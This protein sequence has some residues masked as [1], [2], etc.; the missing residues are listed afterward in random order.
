MNAIS[1]VFLAFAM[2]TDAFAASIG[3]GS[4]LHR[5][6][7][8]E[9]LR[10]GLIF[11]VIEAITPVI[12]WLLGQ[13]AS[14]YVEQWD[15]WIAFVLLVA[16]GAHMVHA[17]LKTDE[18]EEEKQ[19]QHS[20]WILAV[21]AVA[22][23]IDALAVGVGLAFIDVNIWVAAVAIGL[24]TMIMVTLGTL[25]GRALGSVVGK[26]AEIIGGVVLMLVG[27]TILYEHLSAV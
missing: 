19:T 18:Q 16:L 26:R 6:R 11:G 23:S 27:A 15:H 13:A 8:L 21:T 14:Q 2:S 7:L 9:A 5:P 20:F 25:L 1:L 3:K 22:T 24:A 12:G 17:G 4:S 10:T